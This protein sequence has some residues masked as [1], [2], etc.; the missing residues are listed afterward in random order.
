M[1]IKVLHAANAILEE[2]WSGARTIG[3]KKRIA[4]MG[5]CGLRG[6]EML[7]IELAGTANSLKHLEDKVNPHFKFILL[8]LR[9]ISC[10]VPG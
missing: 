3:Q 9:G 2:Q 5:A 10:R 6:K 1:S 7:T 4:E 8:G